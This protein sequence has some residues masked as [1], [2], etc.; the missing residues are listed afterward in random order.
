MIAGTY[1]RSSNQ[2]NFVEFTPQSWR[3]EPILFIA[4][5]INR[6]KG[7]LLFKHYHKFQR[8]A[9]QK[10]NPYYNKVCSL[11]V[12]KVMLQDEI[13]TDGYRKCIIELLTL[14]GVF[15]ITTMSGTYPATG[16]RKKY[17]VS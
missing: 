2:C 14:H 4:M 6:S 12:P 17:S 1:H 15:E 13:T 3:N 7:L 10:W 9:V 16:K 8:N 5:R 11:I